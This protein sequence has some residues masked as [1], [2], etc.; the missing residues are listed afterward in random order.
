MLWLCVIILPRRKEHTRLIKASNWD[1]FEDWEEKKQQQKK[2][3]EALKEKKK[4]ILFEFGRSF[5][6]L[7]KRKS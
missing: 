2:K 1:Y 5:F 6:F 4:V 7:V 3:T